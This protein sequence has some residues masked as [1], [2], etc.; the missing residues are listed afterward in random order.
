MLGAATLLLALASINIAGIMLARGIARRGEV[1]S[2]SC[3]RRGPKP[4]G[5]TAHERSVLLALAG[6]A[7][8]VLLA[9]F[10]VLEVKRSAL[11]LLPRLEEVTADGG[12]LVFALAVT[13]LSAA[14]FGAVPAAAL[15]A[16]LRVRLR[17]LTP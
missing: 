16:F 6:G 11:A 17:A 3:A 10:A 9:H 1:R 5:T 14:W 4:A 7:L 12:V 15:A 8:G 2:A 13:L